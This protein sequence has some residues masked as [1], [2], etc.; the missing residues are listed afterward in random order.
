VTR[1]RQDVSPLDRVWT[2][3]QKAQFMAAVVAG[4]TYALARPAFYA[5]LVVFVVGL[6]SE[7]WRT[8][9]HRK[10][11]RGLAA[12]MA[13]K[14]TS[15]FGGGQTAQRI[16]GGGLLIIVAAPFA[17]WLLWAAVDDVWANPS[18]M[19][20]DVNVLVATFGDLGR[21]DG[22]T[23]PESKQLSIWLAD[24]LQ[25]R[26]A[27]QTEGKTVEIRRVD[28]V[29]HEADALAAGNEVGASLIIY[30]EILQRDGS[31]F[32]T[33]RFTFTGE[34]S[35]ELTSID[36]AELAGES[37]F[38]QPIGPIKT[39]DLIGGSQGVSARCEVIVWF[40]TGLVS[41]L[42][43]EEE[44]ADIFDRTMELT[45]EVGL[46]DNEVLHLFRGKALSASGTLA[47]YRNALPEFEAAVRVNPDYARPYIG[48][49]NFYYLAGAAAPDTESL[50][51]AVDTYTQAMSAPLR[52][53][54]PLAEAK[55]HL[56]RGNAYL[57]LAQVAGIDYAP[58]A[59]EEYE[60]VADLNSPCG[61]GLGWWDP[62]AWG[63][64]HDRFYSR[65]DYCDEMSEMTRAAEEGLRFLEDLQPESLTLTTTPR[66]AVSPPAPTLTATPPTAT[67]TPTPTA[68]PYAPLVPPV[69][70]GTTTPTLTPTA[71]LYV[72]PPL[73]A[74]GVPPSPTAWVPSPPTAT[75]APISSPTPWVPKVLPPTGGLP[76]LRTSIAV[77]PNGNPM[78]SYQGEG[79]KFAVCDLSAS[80]NGNCD[81]TADWNT[82][83]VDATEGAG[84][85]MSIAADA[86]GNPMISYWAQWPNFGLKFAIC[87]LSTSANGNCDQ[88][89]DWRT[90]TVD[91][92]EGVKWFMS[93]AADADGNPMISYMYST[94]GDYDLKFAV[95]DLST[96]A[97][98]NCDQT[99]DWR[100][101][102]VDAT[103][104]AGWFT[105][106]A[107]DAD[108][109]PMI[110][111]RAQ[112]PNFGLK[113]AVCDLSAS[114]NGNCDQTADWSTVTVGE[115]EGEGGFTSIAA[116]ADGNPMISYWAQWPNFGLKFA[117]CDLS[118]SANGNC[119]QTT[120][121]NTVTVDPTEIVA[122]DGISIAVGTNG[123][124]VIS[125][126]YSTDED[127]RL[128]FAVCDLSASTNGNCDQTADWRTVDVDA[129]GD[130]EP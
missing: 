14:I 118:A 121:W 97:N 8:F 43:G 108:G 52:P 15:W 65:P 114:A 13:E 28:S 38:G 7:I 10:H 113:F 37:G 110:S 62:R 26:F 86:D 83:T 64:W 73:T 104:G 91:A 106:I 42:A 22:G 99:A 68:T 55:A 69:T 79:L 5:F 58:L 82:V 32:V 116:D 45:E 9:R 4:L 3:L 128:K 72:P 129:R 17:A 57:V 74:T 112:W 54:S 76:I 24:S 85:F 40:A 127:Y 23:S 101:V 107:A 39:E 117:V 36:L 21:S 44:A 49:A 125:Y 102:T 130:V 1:H 92:T 122:S 77:A 29:M 103:E 81:Q 87:D 98:G 48:I 90:V 124:P 27:S 120:D 115:T 111:Y 100:T 63:P 60:A 119:D 84:W 126:T 109:N 35:S 46:P 67:P 75:G 70:P 53:S 11:V 59:T 20:G 34:G 2:W 96:S 18:T 16:L 78:V 94:D 47:A 123:D 88:T 80:A 105:S 71:T 66:V 93:I 95:C 51:T 12:R 41:L 30:G 61:G 31:I 56:G 89:A 50:L 19:G 6:L 33:P 25:D